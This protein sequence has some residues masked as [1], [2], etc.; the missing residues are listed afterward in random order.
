MR[1]IPTA[2]T[3]AAFAGASIPALAQEPSFDLPSPATV[4][5]TVDGVD[6]TLGELVVARQNLPQQYAALPDD[7]LLEGLLDQLVQQELLSQALDDASARIGYEMSVHERELRARDSV[8]VLT[9][10]VDTEE[11]IQARYDELYGNA[12]PPT[13]WNASH[14][15]VETEEAAAE[16]KARAEAG[17]AFADL[18]A[19]L[20]TGPSGPNGGALGWFGLGRMVPPFEAAVVALE[21]GEISDPV[22]TDFGWHVILLNDTRE[23][24]LP[25]LEEVRNTIA[26]E[27][28]EIAF[29]E[30]LEAL[31]TEA[32]ITFPD[33]SDIPPEVLRQ[34]A[35]LE[36]E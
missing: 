8:G 4:V 27:L 24:P 34:P 19:E 30:A 2:L 15:L 35:M 9:D 17:E 32:E 11:A 1:S 25:A 26:L 5:A 18:A 22:Q 31:R 29:T 33:I 28:Q 36:L 14:I 21:V 7:V 10:G 13:E 12:T 6:I 23:L 16:A 20:S 3:I